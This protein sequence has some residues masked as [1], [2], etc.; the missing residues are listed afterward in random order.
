MTKGI[1]SDREKALE[2]SYFRQQDAKLLQKLRQNLALNEIAVALAEK[3]RV[4]NPELLDRS[5][6]LGV[7]P[8]TAAAFLLAPLVQIAWAEGSVTKQERETVLRLARERGIESGSPAGMQLENWLHE[9]PPD[10][11]FDAAVAV[12][13]RGLA[14]LPVKERVERIK[15]IVDACHEVAAASGSGLASLLGLGDGVS[16]SEASILDALSRRLRRS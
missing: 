11:L 12:I 5:I 3:L 4:D 13:Q 10:A 7:T 14:V 15:G 16:R 6:N 8:D 1:L 9:R 2:E